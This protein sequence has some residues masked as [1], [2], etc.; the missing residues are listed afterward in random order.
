MELSLLNESVLQTAMLL[1][2]HEQ[3]EK[4]Y[5]TASNGGSSFHMESIQCKMDEIQLQM[6]DLV[7]ERVHILNHMKSINLSEQLTSEVGS[8]CGVG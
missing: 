8:L 5:T 7:A 6:N 2:K 4:E 1:N 3:Q